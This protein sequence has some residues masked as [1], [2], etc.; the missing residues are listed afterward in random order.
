MLGPV[1]RVNARM[2]PLVL[3]G[4]HW[5]SLS[6]GAEAEIGDNCRRV[7]SSINVT[8][9]EQKLRN[10]RHN[11]A[12]Y[13]VNSTKQAT[14]NFISK[15]AFFCAADFLKTHKQKISKLVTSC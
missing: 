7:L 5:V 4:L 15:Q 11:L 8:T 12:H 9:D 10:V 3:L 2:L 14:S 13:G 1:T 6:H